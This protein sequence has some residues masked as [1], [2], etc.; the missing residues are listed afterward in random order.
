MGGRLF[1]RFR[2]LSVKRTFPFISTKLYSSGDG[3]SG[4]Q[5]FLLKQEDFSV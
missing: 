3:N 2:I 1:N 4:L 5:G